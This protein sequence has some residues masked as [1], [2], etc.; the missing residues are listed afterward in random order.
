MGRGER[1][2]V[3]SCWGQCGVRRSAPRPASRA[4][5]SGT[6]AAQQQRTRAAP[7]VPR[8]PSA[9]LHLS[10]LVHLVW[11]L[12]MVK[13]EK[14]SHAARGRESSASRSASQSSRPVTLAQSMAAGRYGRQRRRRGR[15]RWLKLPCTGLPCAGGEQPLRPTRRLVRRPLAL[16]ARNASAARAAA[17][18]CGLLPL[19]P[20]LP[21]LD[22]SNNVS[23][24]I[25]Y[26]ARQHWRCLNRTRGRSRMNV[27]LSVI[28]SVSELLLL[29]AAC[30]AVL[31]KCRKCR[32][33]IIR[34]LFTSCTA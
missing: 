16:A 4:R 7:K 9:P 24:A 22:F 5:G 17:R 20:A 32:G 28:A 21:P 14:N 27:E 30:L 3:A 8:S 25:T 31:F 23:S 12:G 33:R 11:F 2:A 15:A 1:R 13:P 6:A 29:L 34:S 26:V 19:L 18:A 10:R